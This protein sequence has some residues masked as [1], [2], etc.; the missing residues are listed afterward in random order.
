MIYFDFY[1]RIFNIEF[2]LFNKLLELFVLKIIFF[3]KLSKWGI[4]R[5]AEH[6]RLLDWHTSGNVRTYLGGKFKISVRV[7]PMA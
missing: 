1:N 3:L 6:V 5:V 7:Y 4:L 2:V